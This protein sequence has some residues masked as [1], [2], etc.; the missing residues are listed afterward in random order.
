M[1]VMKWTLVLTAVTL[2]FSARTDVAIA[3]SATESGCAVFAPAQIVPGQDFDVRVSRVP[4]Y[5]GGWLWPTVLIRVAYPTNPGWRSVQTDQKTVPKM[6][7]IRTDFT[8][9]ASSALY[10]DPMGGI[11]RGG[12]AYILAIVSE[13][14][15]GDP[16]R[17]LCTASAVIAE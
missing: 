7:V 16:I 15:T 8:L 4:G 11:V 14:T 3:Q 12:T 9:K 6:G 17:T 13:P 10:P 5:P 1:R 2:A